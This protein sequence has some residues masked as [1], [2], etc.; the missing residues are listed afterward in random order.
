[1][2]EPET[3]WECDWTQTE[4]FKQRILALKKEYTFISLAEVTAHLKLDLFRR[5]KYAAL[6]SDDGWASLK[7]IVPWLA[8]QKI[9]VTLFLNPLYFD[10]FHHQSRETERLLSEEEIQEIV[11]TYS[12]FVSIASHGWMHENC[13]ELPI[14]EFEEKVGLAE[15]A[16][17][18]LDGKIPFYAFAY[19]FYYEEELESLRRMGLTPV[20]MDGEMNY[21]DGSFIHRELLDG[22]ILVLR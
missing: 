2:F 17:E 18:R 10:G 15:M 22:N 12:P 19:G 11:N 13:E 16:L 8:E 6:T 9:P 5:K 14:G 7:N 21:S 3:M 20:L 1:M 4:Q